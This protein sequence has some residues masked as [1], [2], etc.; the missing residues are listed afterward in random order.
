MFCIF[1][2]FFSCSF[3]F[4]LFFF[5][6]FGSNIDI[7]FLTMIKTI[8]ISIFFLLIPNFHFFFFFF[9]NFIELCFLFNNFVFQF[10][11]FFTKIDKLYS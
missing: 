2:V 9:L 1:F 3:F 5:L 6:F 8:F 10:I 4:Y 11:S 7:S